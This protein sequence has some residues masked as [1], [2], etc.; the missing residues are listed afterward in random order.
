MPSSFQFK[1][2]VDTWAKI[3][4]YTPPEAPTRGKIQIIQPLGLEFSCHFQTWLVKEKLLLLAFLFEIS[5][6]YLVGSATVA[7]RDPKII[8]AMYKPATLRL[9]SH[10]GWDISSGIPKN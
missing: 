7:P 1:I 8:P 2:N 10:P 3:R 5:P 9:P 4:A 6:K